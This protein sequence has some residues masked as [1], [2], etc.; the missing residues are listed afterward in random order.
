[1]ATPFRVERSHVVDAPPSAVFPLL[2]DL[3]RWTVWSPWED[4]DPQ[5]KRTYGGSDAGV[6]ATYAWSGNRK[7][8]SGSMVVQGVTADERVEVGVSFLK[9]FPADNVTVFTLTPTGGGGTTVR[10]EMTGESSGF[11]AVMARLGAMDKLVGKDFE[12]G[13]RR[14]GA[15]AG[16]TSGPTPG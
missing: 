1:M 9:P 4:T 13:L 16:T 11:G 8:G 3:H 5:L 2:V 6:G 15:A 12:K 7:A 14:L 10:W